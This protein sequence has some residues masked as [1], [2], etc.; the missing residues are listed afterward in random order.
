M[1]GGQCDFTQLLITN[2]HLSI[3][4]NIFMENHKELSFNVINVIK[5]GLLIYSLEYLPQ[6]ENVTSETI[7]KP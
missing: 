1:G 6:E 2:L 3:L 5:S 7:L 4:E